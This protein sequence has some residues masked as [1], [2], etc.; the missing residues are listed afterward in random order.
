LPTLDNCI[1]GLAPGNLVILG[2]RTGA[3]K[4][5]VAT[6][7]SLSAAKA[8]RSTVYIALEQPRI[9]IFLS[10]L[11]KTSG[12]LPAEAREGLVD[13]DT[14]NRALEPMKSLPLVIE[15]GGF[16]LRRLTTLIRR[17][18][19]VHRSEV[20]VVDYLQ[21]TSNRLHGQTRATELAGVSAELKRLALDLNHADPRAL[22]VLPRIGPSR[23]AAIVRA[24]EEAEFA[25]VEELAR[26]RGIGPKT[27]EGLAGWVEVGGAR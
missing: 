14:L 23:A 2:A 12:I 18:H 21:L 15:S 10:L 8:G 7:W 5:T 16:T 22:E 6:D 13:P 26:V 4:T 27:I 19:L 1:G 9:E 20:V 3:G 17:A 24:R 25:S 11:Q